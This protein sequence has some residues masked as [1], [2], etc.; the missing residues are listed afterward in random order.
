MQRDPLGLPAGCAFFLT[1]LSRHVLSVLR[2]L[3]SC[4][5]WLKLCFRNALAAA[6]FTPQVSEF[7]VQLRL[8]A[9]RLSP[10]ML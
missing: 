7:E 2:L 10:R 6:R 1:L 9:G 8:L 3:R 5:T 4:S